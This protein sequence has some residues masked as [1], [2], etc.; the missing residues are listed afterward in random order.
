MN[1]KIIP[2]NDENKLSTNV[3][4]SFHIMGDS[5]IDYKP[6]FDAFHNILVSMQKCT[7]CND[8]T[9]NKILLTRAEGV[10]LIENDAARYSK[11]CVFT[12]NCILTWF[13]LYKDEDDIKEFVEQFTPKDGENEIALYT[14]FVQKYA[15][16]LGNTCITTFVLKRI[17]VDWDISEC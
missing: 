5:S 2:G 16:P 7:G 6:V 9:H 1:N 4:Y 10:S 15:T 8:Y 12:M 14:L 11:R 17:V 3:A 13:N